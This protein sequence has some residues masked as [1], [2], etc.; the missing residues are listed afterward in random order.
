MGCESAGSGPVQS[1]ESGAERENGCRVISANRKWICSHL[2]V[3]GVA[4]LGHGALTVHQEAVPPPLLGQGVLVAL[5]DVAVQLALLVADGLHVL[6]REKNQHGVSGT[7]LGFLF[8][9]ALKLKCCR[10]QR[11]H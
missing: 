9:R 5:G 6:Q 1:S 2:A 7:L 11:K 10:I 8:S 4:V 3:V